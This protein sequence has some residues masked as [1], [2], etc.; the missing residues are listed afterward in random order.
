MK[1]LWI[2]GIIVCLSACD[3]GEQKWEINPEEL[4]ENAEWI[5]SAEIIP[6]IDSLL[7]GDIQAPLFRK[8]FQLKKEVARANLAITAAGYYTVWI[9]GKKVSDH[10]LS[11]AWTDYAK[12]VYYRQF[13]VSDLLLPGENVVAVELG[14]GWYNPLPLR[15][16]GHKN[17]REHLSIGRPCFI[18]LLEYT[19]GLKTHHVASDSSW[20][21]MP[22]PVTRNNVYLGEWHNENLNPIGWMQPEFD[23][24]GW[25]TVLVSTG[26]GGDLFKADFPPIRKTATLEPQDIWQTGEGKLIIDFGQNTAGKIVYQGPTTKQDTLIF[27]YGE[28][29]WEDSTLNPMTAVC[30]QIK[31]PGAGGPGAPDIADQMDVFIPAGSSSEFEPRYTYHGFRYL[32]ISGLNDINPEQL[33][34]RVKAYR[35]GSDV[36]DIGTIQASQ[37]WI[38]DIEN[39]VKWTISSNIFSV[40]SDC[41]A[42]EKFGYGGDIIQNAEAF[43]Y[44]YDM[45]SFFEKFI[46]DW[47]DAMRDDRFVDTAPYVG[48]NYC[49]ISWEG[50]FLLLQDWLYRFYGDLDLVRYW[51]DFNLEWMSKVERLTGDDLVRKGLSDHESLLPVPVEVTGTGHYLQCLNIMSRFAELLDRQELQTTYNEKADQVQQMMVDSLWNQPIYEMKNPQ[52]WLSCLLFHNVLSPTEAEYAVTQLIEDLKSREFQL[53]TGIFGTPYLLEVLSRY[54]YAQDAYTMISR[55]NFPGWRHMLNNGATTLWET[56]EESDNVF[57]QNHPMF[58]AVSTW[59]HRWLGGID[60]VS[61]GFDSCELHPAP[62]DGVDDF[63]VSRQLPS[64]ELSLKWERVDG[65][66]E[67][68]V[69]VPEVVAK[70]KPQ[71]LTQGQLLSIRNTDEVG[72]ITVSNEGYHE[73]AGPGRFIIVYSE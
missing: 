72:A 31:R 70:W 19:V 47:K 21:W 3:K 38:E 34:P 28:R 57:S 62:V 29:I 69:Q 5:A 11:P 65:K 68:V 7:Y 27:R 1:Y 15:M 49:G 23:D 40:P 67:F 59:I 18:A 25:P 50:S 35:M 20:N 4:I 55:E 6:D 36:A 2:L 63:K 32:E 10:E 41:P 14:N 39:V 26:P 12:R 56:W 52:T 44:N 22:G 66:I 60:P 8:T 64:G 58:A 51:F 48:I 30:G 24:L 42:R 37:K 43:L 17:L 33:Y 16:W 54:G 9:N 53:T 61:G 45:K 13:D 71:L 46:F 73:F